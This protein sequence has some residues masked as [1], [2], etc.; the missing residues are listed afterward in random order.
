[1]KKAGFL[2]FVMTYSLISTPAFSQDP[3]QKALARAQY[4]LKQVSAEKAQLQ[5]QLADAQDEVEQLKKELEAQLSSAKKKEKKLKGAIGNWKEEYEKLKQRF[6]AT[7]D[8]LRATTQEKDNYV[9]RY[10]QRTENYEVCYNHNNQLVGV[11]MEL[12]QKFDAKGAWDALIQREPV[13]GL[14][15]VEIENL[16]QKYTHQIEDLSLGL[17]QHLLHSVSDE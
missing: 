5:G 9:Q 13:T 16:V 6:L 14:G 1:M 12:V 10:T 8:Q 7:S 3:S 11:N 17:N 4:M 15:K 2:I